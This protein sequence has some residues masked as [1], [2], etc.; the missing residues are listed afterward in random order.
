[1]CGNQSNSKFRSRV[2]TRFS[3]PK[4]VRTI[5]PVTL[6]THIVYIMSRKGV[7]KCEHLQVLN[8]L[9]EW[10]AKPRKSDFL[11]HCSANSASCSYPAR[12]FV[13]TQVVC[14]VAKRCFQQAKA[15]DAESFRR[16]SRLAQQS[17]PRL[18]SRSLKPDKVP[19]RV[20][21]YIPSQPA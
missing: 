15:D 3:K 19:N 8:H 4:R 20:P 16:K 10:L 11:T 9:P 13:H 14:N 21:R 7:R 5:R 6:C 12:N 17:N 18:G 2:G 1:M